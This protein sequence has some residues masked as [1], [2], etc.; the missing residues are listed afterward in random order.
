V[1]VPAKP[2]TP[3]ATAKPGLFARIGHGIRKL[4][5]RAPSSQH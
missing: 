4:I 2:T 3:A 1:N 5:T